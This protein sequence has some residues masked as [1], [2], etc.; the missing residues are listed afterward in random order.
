MRE[1]AIELVAQDINRE[2]FDA[3]KAQRSRM[4]VYSDAET[5]IS[6]MD[7]FEMLH[8]IGRLLDEREKAEPAT[9]TT[10]DPLKATV[11]DIVHRMTHTLVRSRENGIPVRAS[12]VEQWCYELKQAIGE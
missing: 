7:N 12:F 5:R 11:R 8:L 2:D 4:D 1:E 3:G 10:P 6:N 9:E